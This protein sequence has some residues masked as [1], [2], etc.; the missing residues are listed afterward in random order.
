MTKPLERGL[1][2]NMCHF[3]HI[4]LTTQQGFEVFAATT[5]STCTM[6]VTPIAISMTVPLTNWYTS[7]VELAQSPQGRTEADPSPS[8]QANKKKSTRQN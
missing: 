6:T 8:V 1:P 2:Q 7:S 4:Q 5:Y 3:Y